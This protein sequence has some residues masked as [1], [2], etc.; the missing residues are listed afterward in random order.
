MVRRA[1]AHVI[2]TATCYVGFRVYKQYV[3]P[4][5]FE[6]VA[7]GD[8]PADVRAAMGEP[9]FVPLC[10][11][12]ACREECVEAYRNGQS[13][14]SEWWA[15]CLTRARRSSG[16]ATSSRP[17]A[18][19]TTTTERFDRSCT[20]TLISTTRIERTTGSFFSTTMTPSSP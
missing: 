6:S 2:A 8:S 13:I 18:S 16:R 7:I 4:A 3:Y 17:E 20:A 9:D 12:F 5:D 10:P 1:V 11:S 15:I 14:P 19:R